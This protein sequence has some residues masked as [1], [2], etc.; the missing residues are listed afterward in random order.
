MNRKILSIVLPIAI[1]LLLIVGLLCLPG[2]RAEAGI[3]SKAPN[4][5]TVPVDYVTVITVT[6]GTD[7]DDSKSKTCYTDPIGPPGPPTSPCTLRRAMVE[8]SALDAS[9]RPILIKFDIPATAGE[10]YDASLDAW[11]IDLY[12]TTETLALGR[13]KDGQITID[14]TTQPGGRSDG[15]KIIL[16]GPS[17]GNKDGF[18][19]GDVAGDDENV[20]RGL[21]FQNF[22]T[23][24]YVNTDNNTIED[25]WFGLSGD[26]TDI[27][28]RPAGAQDGSGNTGVSVSDGADTNLIQNNVFAGL[29]GVAAAINGNDNT[30]ANNYIGTT[31]DG[32]VP[33]KQTDPD[34]ICTPEDWLGGSGISMDGV[35]NIIEDNIFAGLRL[36]VELP[37]IQPDAIRMGGDEHI[38]RNNL[39][40][41]DADGTSVG[42][43]GRGIYLVN[44]PE[45]NELTDNTIVN[46]G[47]SA[48]SINDVLADADTLRGN[49]IKQTNNW[50]EIEGNAK[51]ED[52]I[53][54][55]SS[56]PDVYENFKPAKVTSIEG[57]TVT[58][59]SGD[60]SLC[61]DCTIEVFLDDTDIITEALQSL[62]VVDADA[63]GNWTATLP[64]ELSDTQGLRTTSTTPHYNTISG[65][66]A[67][68]TTGLSELYL[69]VPPDLNFYIFLSLVWK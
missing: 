55:G 64:F 1:P 68:T 8:A 22:K 24:L 66:S 36:E 56:L 5:P 23:H 37:T 43:C 12:E 34:L 10:G 44:A 3:T 57:T 6:S 63:D 28:L 38:I 47:Y 15:P 51:P 41:V 69:A 40:G 62:A 19:V 2:N 54:L 26:G 58:G 7:P 21:G 16:Y 49:I 35:G 11:I 45:F 46:T 65:M 13:L 18:V 30:F 33:E 27:A 52:A 4:P 48:I 31:A 17:G 50:G 61:E 60:N 42:V 39:I 14:G 59:T 32:T 29:A 9:A 20:I 25:N 67:G 53:Q